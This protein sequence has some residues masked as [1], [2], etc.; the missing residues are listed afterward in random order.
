MET[1]KQI[2]YRE[3]D[4]AIMIIPTNEDVQIVPRFI[5]ELSVED[6]AP[7][8]NILSLCL[9]KVESISYMIYLAEEDR[10]DIQ[11]DDTN[12]ICLKISEL[13]ESEKQIVEAAN[14]VYSKLL[15]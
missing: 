8:N 7:I 6:K 2:I 9:T 15:N 10:L 5:N 3:E 11:T 13:E 1:F 14:S 4:G 12:T